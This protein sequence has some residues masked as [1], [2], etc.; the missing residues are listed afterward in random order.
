ML[1]KIKSVYILKGIFENLSKVKNLKI[2]H[3]NKYLNNH[4][5]IT[6]NNYKEAHEYIEIKLKLSENYNDYKDKYFMHINLDDRNLNGFEIYF[7]GKKLDKIV[8]TV[9]GFKS[10]SNI[11]IRIKPNIH[12]LHSLFENCK[13]I[14]EINV[15][16]CLRRDL[17]NTSYMFYD[18]S[19]LEKLDVERLKVDNVT[20]MSYMFFGC[21]SLKELILYRYITK[22]AINMEGMFGECY[23]LE[24]LDITSFDT[25]EVTNMSKMFYEDKSLR[26]LD[27]K[28]FNLAKVKFMDKMFYGCS[29]CQTFQLFNLQL[30]PNVNKEKMFSPNFEADINNQPK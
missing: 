5:D 10:V 11:L 17:I 3:R 14:K 1:E 26:N 18:C 6:V 19:G 8:E 21:S 7:D 20:D 27:V 15:I 23:N 28:H 2:S 25:D 12:S 24:N 16:N 13:I 4:L 29:F 30:P 9:E 22:Q